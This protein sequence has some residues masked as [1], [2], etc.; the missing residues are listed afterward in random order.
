[1]LKTGDRLTSSF[2]QYLII[3]QAS[4]R[5][6]TV[7]AFQSIRC[8]FQIAAI[9]AGLDSFIVGGISFFAS[10]IAIGY[11][12]FALNLRLSFISSFAMAGLCFFNELKNLMKK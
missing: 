11:D 9:R 10:L 7:R 4:R 6:D 2:I 12:D 8:K 5:S 1:M 3:M